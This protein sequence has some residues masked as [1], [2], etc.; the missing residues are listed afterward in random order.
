M[1]KDDDDK[2]IIQNFI[3]EVKNYIDKIKCDS[4]LLYPYSH[5]S[6]NLESPKTAYDL[7]KKIEKEL[8]EN[9]NGIKI[10]AAPFGWTKELNLKIKG[11]PLCR[12]F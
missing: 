7:L 10:K 6:S 4:I 5:L 8:K 11:H 1:E 9:L 3:K 2:N 12:E